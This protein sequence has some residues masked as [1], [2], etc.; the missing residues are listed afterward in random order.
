MALEARAPWEFAASVIAAP[1]LLNA[2]K[3]DGHPVLVVPGLA[4]GDFATL[5][6]RNFLAERGYATYAWEQGLNLGLRPGVL[7][8]CIARVRQLRAEHGRTVS[9]IGWSLGGIYAREIAKIIPEDV[10][11]VITLGAPFGGIRIA[12][13]A[14]WLYELASGQPFESGISPGALMNTPPVPTTSIYSRSDGMVAWECS[15]ERESDRSENI[16]IHA[17]HLGMGMN[18]TALYAIADR[19]A[20]TEGEWRRFDRNGHGGITEMLYRDPYRTSQL[21]EF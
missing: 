4:T 3:G 21:V 13:N 15:L 9:V 6:L 2:P 7:E 19:L 14:W 16:E 11:L 1:L 20:Q 12:T 5:V 18:P 8:A 10:R 17:S